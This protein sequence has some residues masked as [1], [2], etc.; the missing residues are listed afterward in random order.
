MSARHLAGS[1][2]RTSAAPHPGGTHRAEADTPRRR[3]TPTPKLQ[4]RNP[5]PQRRYGPPL[6]HA[7]HPGPHRPPRPHAAHPVGARPR[8]RPGSR[9]VRRQPR[10]HPRGP[11]AGIDRHGHVPPGGGPRPRARTHPAGS[12]PRRKR[13]RFGAR[14]PQRTHRDAGTLGRW[15]LHRLVQASGACFPRSV[16]RGGHRGRAARY[17]RRQALRPARPRRRQV[18]AGRRADRAR[19]LLPGSR[20]CRCAPVD[21]TRPGTLS[22]GVGRTAPGGLHDCHLGGLFGQ[23]ERGRSGEV[24][25]AAG[26]EVGPHM[27]AVAGERGL[28]HGPGRVRGRMADNQRQ[29]YHDEQ[30]RIADRGPDAGSR[31]RG[32]VGRADPGQWLGPIR[33]RTSCSSPG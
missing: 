31:C 14:C 30:L 8:L 25:V 32:P 2:S 21:G 6:L 4:P 3:P 24:R 28:A 20:P 10:L 13:I 29:T 12:L 26:H 1:A 15:I 23:A 19:G 11:T 22:R 5:D 17:E 33:G 27:E 9:P 16:R 7:P 18:V